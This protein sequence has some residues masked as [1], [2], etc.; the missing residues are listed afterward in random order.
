MP[1]PRRNTMSPV[2]SSHPAGNIVC[3]L[4]LLQDIMVAVRRV[5]Q[6][7]VFIIVIITVHKDRYNGCKCKI[8]IKLFINNNGNP[9]CLFLGICCFSAFPVQN[10]TKLLIQ[11]TGEEMKVG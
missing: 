4:L 1:P 2:L 8:L 5:R 9:L 11:V 3:D 7:A 6:I 10:G